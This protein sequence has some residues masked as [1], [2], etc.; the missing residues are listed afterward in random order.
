MRRADEQAG[1]YR[2]L[3]KLLFYLA[4]GKSHVGYLANVSS[5]P[6]V[7]KG[8]NNPFPLLGELC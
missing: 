2:V 4:S 6:F 3:A 8:V 1:L 7:A 5:N